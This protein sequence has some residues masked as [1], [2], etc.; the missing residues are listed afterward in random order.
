M[1]NAATKTVAAKVRN[2]NSK[3]ILRACLIS[4]LVG[5]S[6]FTWGGC[7]RPKHRSNADNEARF[8]LNEKKHESGE[9]NPGD[10]GIEVD[11]S[12]RMF[13]PFNP[14]RPPM[15]EDDPQSNRYMRLVDHKKGYPL[16]EANGRTNA[17][18]NPDWVSQLPL[19]ERGVLVLDLQQ[20]VCLSLLHSPTYQ[21]NL[22][23]VYLSALDVSSER[24]RFDSQF[25]GGWSAGYN[26][27]GPF[28]NNSPVRNPRSTFTTGPA[29]DGRRDLGF[30][31]RFSTGTDLVVGLAN[32]ISWQFVGPGRQSSTTLLDFSLVQPLLRQAGR[33]VVLERLTLAE[34]TLLS[35]VRAFERYRRAFYVQIA[36]GLNPD[37]QPQRRGGVFGGAGFTGFTG[38]GGGFGTLGGNQQGGGNA[39]LAGQ[40]NAPGA[41]GFF[42]LLQNQLQIL[43]QQETVAQ[44][45]D[46]YLQLRDNFNE[47]LLTVPETQIQIPQQKLQV[48]QALQNIYNQQT[49]LLQS[50]AAFQDSMDNF[51]GLL[52]LPP[53]VC[54]EI[55]DPLLDRFKL[56]SEELRARRGQLAALRASIGDKNTSIL[57]LSTPERDP[58]TRETFRSIQ[59]RPELTSKLTDLA[60]E[61]NPLAQIKQAIVER[62][63]AEVRADIDRLRSAIPTRRT[64][65][66]RLKEIVKSEEGAICALLPTGT[67]NLSFL[68]GEGLEMLPD[69]LTKQLTELEAKFEKHT[70]AYESLQQKIADFEAKKSAI[71]NDRQRFSIVSKEIILGSQ[72]LVAAISEDLLVAQLLQARAR[73]EAALLPE[74]DLDPREAFEIA[75]IN[76][77]DWLN[78]RAA[79]VN[80]WRAIEVVADE[81]ESFLDFTVSGDVQNYGPNPLAM[82]ADTG[83]VQLGLEW[84]APITR[85]QERN[86]YRQS[87]I[88]YQRAKR[89]YY[90]Y[91]DGV[92][93]SMRSTLRTIRQRQL[94]FEIQ[95]FAVQTA[96]QQ[97]GVNEDIRQINETLGQ[98]SPTAARDAITALSDL[99]STQSDLIGT[100]VN[101]EALRRALD[102]NMGTMQL[103][104]EGMWIDPGP[105]RADVLG[106][107][108]GESVMT[109]GMTEN[110][111]E[112]R[113]QMI[114]RGDLP[115]ELAPSDRLPPSPINTSPQAPA[116]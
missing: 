59:D 46:I 51:K 27:T 20:A 42:G 31:R 53:Y 91:E 44:L 79:V 109:Y 69:D 47:L 5:T 33:D 97:I 54:V 99:L 87:L 8:L 106:G 38:L 114:S 94:S 110:E 96:T 36:V 17:A 88:E 72:D 12:S 22:E 6:I 4:G 101:Y 76:R 13:D 1:R 60:N 90:R 108:F 2:R 48:V 102:L 93:Q 26:T 73:T 57:D 32:D 19:D 18:E 23:E 15:P 65:L 77:H 66:D 67:L 61:L 64:Q 85:L 28:R 82:R 21:R 24:F 111:I 39:G 52:G 75:R 80:S 92:F 37:T 30:S 89:S 71:E 50:Q 9:V 112:L 100:F 105:M 95:R 40:G 35:N 115:I 83:R 3:S 84:D 34:R 45:T 56:V 116:N 86:N 7:T 49:T 43:N 78:N 41:A 10:Y 14:D 98:V 68:D 63:F 55:N 104:S 58:D 103:D 29:S 74:V 11:P 25:F 81:L 16:W 62:D 70:K 107:V 113:D